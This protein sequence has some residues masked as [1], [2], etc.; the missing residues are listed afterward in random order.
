[1][2]FNRYPEPRNL[3]KEMRLPIP[4]DYEVKGENYYEYA[5]LTPPPSDDEKESPKTPEFRGGRSTRTRR[6]KKSRGQTQKVQGQKAQP[7]VKKYTTLFTRVW[8]IHGKN[9]A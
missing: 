6:Y 7:P 5:P 4:Y 2:V 9:K 8:K 1:M 3:L